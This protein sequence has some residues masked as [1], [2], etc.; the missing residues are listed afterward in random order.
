MGRN[1]KRRG[2][3]WRDNKIEEGEWS[4]VNEKKSKEMQMRKE[5]EEE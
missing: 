3:D 1:N 5:N 2:R 4:K